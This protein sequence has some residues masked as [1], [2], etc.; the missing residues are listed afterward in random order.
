[1]S[2]PSRRRGIHRPLRDLHRR[3]AGDDRQAGHLRLLGE[4]GQLELRRGTLGVEARQQHA[5][6][7][8]FAEPQGQLARGGGLAGALQADHQDRYRRRGVQVDR[9]G[10]LAAQRL[11]HHV[12]DDLDDLLAGRDGGQDLG[13]DG[14]LAHLGDEVAH[15]GQRHVGVQQRQA[16]FAECLGDVG[17]G[18]RTATAQA[19][20]YPGQLV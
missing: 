4:L 3:L 6:P 2:K 1:M 20:E 5:P 10:A 12:I 11:D 18:Q 14:A 17:L 13:A 8:A 16:D 9:D 7:H 15:H 19:V